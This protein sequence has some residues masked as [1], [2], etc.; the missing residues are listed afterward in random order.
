MGKKRRTQVQFPADVFLFRPENRDRAAK[1]KPYELTNKMGN[2]WPGIWLV[3]AFVLA[4]GGGV[5]ALFTVGVGSMI[6]LIQADLNRIQSAEAIIFVV[7]GGVVTIPLGGIFFVLLR[8]SFGMMQSVKPWREQN[9]L[10]RKGQV[11]IGQVVAVH[12][13]LKGNTWEVEFD[14]QPPDGEVERATAEYRRRPDGDDAP[15]PQP[16]ERMAVLYVHDEL[17]TPL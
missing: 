3:F 10:L 9:R 4:W 16:G 2:P 17:F 5:V 8:A 1:G 7:A 13:T 6:D 12:D 15:P 11:S 14:F